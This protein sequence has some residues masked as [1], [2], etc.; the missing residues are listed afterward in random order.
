MFG[1][2]VGIGKVCNKRHGS[3]VASTAKIRHGTPASC[4]I[5]QLRDGRCQPLGITGAEVGRREGR[6]GKLLRL[7]LQRLDQ[8]KLD[9]T[10][11]AELFYQR[12]ER[13]FV[14]VRIHQTLDQRLRGYELIEIDQDVDHPQQFRGRGGICFQQRLRDR[15]DRLD[16]YNGRILSPETLRTERH[17]RRAGQYEHAG[18]CSHKG[19][20]LWEL[21]K[22]VA[23]PPAAS[24]EFGRRNVDHQSCSFF[25]HSV[26]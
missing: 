2:A 9:E 16:L 12:G 8:R 5:G 24:A 6:R 23:P 17:N 15:I 1:R 21:L 3:R 4:R 20:P 25:R 18:S 22:L 19:M 13:G 10:R 11:R 14:E 26:N 7:G